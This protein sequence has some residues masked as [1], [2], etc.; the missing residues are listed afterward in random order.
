M[1]DKTPLEQVKERQDQAAENLE[2]AHEESL[3]EHS[4]IREQENVDIH[5]DAPGGIGKSGQAPNPRTQPN[6]QG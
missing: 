4:H 1:S 5:T 2:A 3:K 6:R